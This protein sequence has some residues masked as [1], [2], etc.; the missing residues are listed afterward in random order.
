MAAEAYIVLKSE[1]GEEAGPF[2]IR[3]QDLGERRAVSA[4]FVCGKHFGV[5]L[6][7]PETAAL[8]CAEHR[9]T[10]E[11]WHAVARIEA[12]WTTS[13]WAEGEG[14]IIDLRGKPIT[15]ADIYAAFGMDEQGRPLA[16]RQRP[17]T[18]ATDPRFQDLHKAL[19]ELVLPGSVESRVSRRVTAHDPEAA[20]RATKARKAARKRERQNRKRGRKHR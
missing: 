12:A 10:R 6:D 2:A 11:A 14:E 4:C 16:R 7:L 19:A 9:G 5:E 18:A 13:P 17:L 3:D 1:D 15:K 8:M 20:R